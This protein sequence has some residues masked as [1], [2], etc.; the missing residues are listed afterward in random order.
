MT[1]N[2]GNK[3]I[4][5]IH[6]LASKPP[7]EVTH[8]LWQR[9]L[10]ENIRVGHRQL[11]QSLDANPGIFE[12]AYWADAVPHHVPDDAGYCKKLGIQVD[13]VRPEI[14]FTSVWARRSVA[15][16]RIVVSTW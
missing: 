16:S 10:I 4:I 14:D 6:G 11:A 8:E 2:L 7:P 12:S 3:K 1:P 9:T 15:F 5:M 13:S